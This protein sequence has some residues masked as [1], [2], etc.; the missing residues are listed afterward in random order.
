MKKE[1][2]M[3]LQKYV[4]MAKKNDKF[5]PE[6]AQ[7]FYYLSKL[8]VEERSED[9]GAWSI[10]MLATIVLSITKIKEMLDLK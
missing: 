4:D 5:S 9:E 6:D 10:F 3:K 2:T 7:N 8:V 1:D